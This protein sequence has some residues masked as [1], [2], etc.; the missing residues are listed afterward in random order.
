MVRTETISRYKTA[1]EKI[2]EKKEIKR[3]KKRMLAQKVLSH[4]LLQL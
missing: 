2:F 4:L 3:N 1:W